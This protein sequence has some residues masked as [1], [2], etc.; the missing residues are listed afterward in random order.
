MCRQNV[1]I[2]LFFI[3]LCLAVL[4]VGCS[5]KKAEIVLEEEPLQ[6]MAK[7]EKEEKSDQEEAEQGTLFVFICGAVTTPGVYELPTES[8]VHEVVQM[9]GGLLAEADQNYLNQAE[10][11]TDGMRIYV[12][13]EGEAPDLQQEGTAK[14]GVQSKV[15][16]NT[17]DKETLMTLT[18]I[19]EAKAAAILKYR[20]EQ[21]PF[22]AI[23][24][25]M[26]IEGI[27]EGVFRK[28]EDEITI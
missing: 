16:I 14:P 26:M 17:A 28:I 13:K 11:L 20:E 19:G 8:R 22:G 9:A 2:T 21:G 24:D 5:E 23:E 3:G 7:T 6:E 27:K 10:R 12:P 18:G 1:K 4:T 15:N 25:L